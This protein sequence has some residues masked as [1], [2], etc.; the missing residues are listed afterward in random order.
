MPLE[1]DKG[2]GWKLSLG[3]QLNTGLYPTHFTRKIPLWKDGSNVQFTST[4]VEKIAGW[5]TL[6][7]PGNGEP[8]RGITQNS[9]DLGATLAVY[10]GDLTKL[11]RY[12]VTNDSFQ[13]TNTG[14]N[15]YEDSGA[16]LW[17]S[18]TTTW[19]SGS[20]LWDE[21]I[22]KASHWSFATFG[23]FI[24]ATNGVDYP[25]IRKGDYNF[26]PMVGG[27]TGIFISS[28]GTGY[29]AGD[30]LTLTGGDG[31]GATAEVV[32]V[33]GTGAITK[34]GI[35]D[36]GTGYTTVPTGFSGGTGSGATFTFSVSDIDVD[37]VRIWAQRGPHVLGFNTSASEKEFIWCDAGDVDTWVAASDNLAGQLEIRELNSP[38]RAA[39]TLGD[40]IA[41][42]GDDQMFLVSYL[43][44]DLVFGYRPALTGIG[45]V[46]QKAIVSVDRKN[47][48]MSQ[49]GF[50]VTD[51]AS[52]EYIDEP[53]IRDYFTDNANKAQLGKAVGFHDENNTQIRWY[54]PT[55]GTTNTSGVSFN[56][57]TNTWS[58]IDNDRSAGIERLILS[59]PIAGS[60]SGVLYRESYEVSA[61]GSAMTAW[62]RTKPM[63]WSNADL[64]KELDSIRIGYV[65]ENLTY[66]IGWS[67]TEDGTINWGDY[68]AMSTGFTFQ[69][70]R[71]A[72][73]YLHF[74]I[75]SST[76]NS[77]WEVEEVEFIGR[78]EGTR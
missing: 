53:A 47:Y 46:S 33:D 66:R 3:D 31:S 29:V 21:G 71:T 13:T 58:V 43:A 75:Y 27:V 41:V 9:E 65:G 25:L 55:D 42:Y 19:D 4:G 20:T 39:V 61:D 40:F 62:A 50:F 1:K 5:S 22:I 48:G 18:G 16:S 24:L 23:S 72:G 73:R 49:Q 36:G 60:E 70:L 57:K 6:Y 67:E 28:A 8:I 10:W 63:D 44:N 74:E 68:T 56:Y 59:S 76:L 2:N 35:N 34:V 64:I 78:M 54:F 17:D 38:I 37:T 52:F 11:Y 30:D 7:D 14:F 12:D 51:G 32:A 69:N 26:S 45:A 15:L 77:S